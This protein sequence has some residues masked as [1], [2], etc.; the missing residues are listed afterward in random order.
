MATKTQFSSFLS[1]I[2][3]SATTKS[4]ASSRHTEL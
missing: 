3:P 4:N 1:D 2:E